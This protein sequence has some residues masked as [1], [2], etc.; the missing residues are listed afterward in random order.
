[1]AAT[2]TF[3]RSQLPASG[4][5]A[6]R[7]LFLGLSCGKLC[8]RLLERDRRL[9]ADADLRELGLLRRRELLVIVLGLRRV[10]ARA[11]LHERELADVRIVLA[12]QRRLEVSERGRV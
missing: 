9:L 8:S 7:P 11:G 10:A 1:R 3:P 2:Q 6:V 5:A 12:A 4:V